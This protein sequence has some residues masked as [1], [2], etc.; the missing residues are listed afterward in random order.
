MEVQNHK[1]VRRRQRRVLSC[2]ACRRRKIKCNREQPCQHCMETRQ[3]CNYEGPPSP[4][5]WQIP[6]RVQKT[7]PKSV[8]K[9]QENNWRSII[10]SPEANTPAG[11]SGSS[12]HQQ[13]SPTPPTLLN[14]P[15]PSHPVTASRH[16]GRAQEFLP[17]SYHA[18]NFKRDEDMFARKSAAHDSQMVLDKTRILRWSHWMGAGQEV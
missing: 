3:Q 7:V 1:A 8:P 6:K 9:A 15:S 10:F 4:Q 5:Q 13:T 17:S 12:N 18:Q 2:M 16:T 11:A 14:S